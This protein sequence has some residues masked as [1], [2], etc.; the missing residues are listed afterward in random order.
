MS[1]NK[2]TSLVYKLLRWSRDVNAIV[3]SIKTGSMKPVTKRA[4]NKLIGRL[5][6]KFKF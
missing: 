5:F 2:F 3:R 1:I 4:G 6:G